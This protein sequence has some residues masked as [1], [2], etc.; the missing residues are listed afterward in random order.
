MNKYEISNI[1][2][3]ITAFLELFWFAGII[4]GYPFLGEHF[5]S[6]IS[7]WS[8]HR[9]VNFLRI[10]SKNCLERIYF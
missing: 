6:K 9:K 4:W 8:I 5:L 2:S 10:R 7:I 1:L 3:L